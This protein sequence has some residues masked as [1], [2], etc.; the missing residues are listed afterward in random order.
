MRR[1]AKASQAEV[2]SKHSEEW[3]QAGGGGRGVMQKSSGMVRRLIILT[4]FNTIIKLGNYMEKFK[5]QS[6]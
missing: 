1:Y 3:L 5:L 2:A 4:S 6:D